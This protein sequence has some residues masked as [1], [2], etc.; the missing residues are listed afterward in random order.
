MN[1][2]NGSDIYTHFAIKQMRLKVIADDFTT[3]RST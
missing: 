1:F 3:W 2:K